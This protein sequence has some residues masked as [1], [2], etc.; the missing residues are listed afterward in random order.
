MSLDIW[1]SIDVDTGGKEPHN[2][3]LF[4]ANYTHNVVPMWKKAGCYDALYMSDGK[5]AGNVLPE[6]EAGLAAMKADP[7][8]F[9]QLNPLNG[10]GNYDSA[11]K[12]LE[13]F[14]EACRA[15]PK[16]TIG[17]SK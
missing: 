15:H 7:E 2:I 14:T 5:L 11:L 4:D 16:T 12:F 17:V 10:W 6:L 9:K 3:T 1:L 13:E 8:G